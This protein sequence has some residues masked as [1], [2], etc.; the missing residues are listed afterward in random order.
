[1]KT[2]IGIDPGARG[3]IAVLHEGEIKAYKMPIETVDIIAILGKYREN[4]FAV[5]EKVNS[6]QAD[7]KEGGKRYG[8]DKLLANYHTLKACLVA[9]NIPY[10]LAHPMTWQAA[11]K[12]RIKGELKPARKERYR[13]IAQ[14][15]YP[16]LRATLWNADALLL[17]ILGAQKIKP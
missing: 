6:F 5:L 17:T 11:L 16:G 12:L 9:Q 4:S 7:L 13:Q 10:V 3:C 1:M 2:I 8:I 15:H 14:I